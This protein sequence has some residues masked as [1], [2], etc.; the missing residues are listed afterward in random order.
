[1][2][3]RKRGIDPICRRLGTVGVVLTERSES[4]RLKLDRECGNQ[5]R[6]KS[7]RLTGG[8]RGPFDRLR[9]GRGNSAHVCRIQPWRWP[10]PILS[11][12]SEFSRPG[13][14]AARGAGGFSPRSHEGSETRDVE[15]MKK[16]WNGRDSADN[17]G[18]GVRRILTT[19]TR[20]S[21]SRGH[22]LGGFVPLWQ[23][24]VPR[25]KESN[26]DVTY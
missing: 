19:K 8:N 11:G 15:F 20:R 2:E 13:G 26:L 23:V 5:E 3:I 18:I 7:I 1:V 4:G 22:L 24:L 25:G 10:G 14:S 16:A 6:G 21:E 17:R 12:R 9:A